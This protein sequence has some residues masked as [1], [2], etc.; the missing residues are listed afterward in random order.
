M[1]I[2]TILVLGVAD[3]KQLQV[4]QDGLPLWRMRSFLHVFIWRNSECW[5]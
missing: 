3:E 4:V 5:I 1:N 2:S